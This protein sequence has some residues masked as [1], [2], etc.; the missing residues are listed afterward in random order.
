M[1]SDKFH[2][3]NADSILNFSNQTV[4]IATNIKNNPIVPTDTGISKLGSSQKTE[5]KA[6]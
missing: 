1:G 2:P 5:N 4:F 6:R 3:N